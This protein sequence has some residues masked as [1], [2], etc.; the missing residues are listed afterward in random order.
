VHHGAGSTVSRILLGEATKPSHWRSEVF[1]VHGATEAFLHG[2]DVR[3]HPLVFVPCEK[4]SVRSHRT[5]HQREVG[6]D[7]RVA[8]LSVPQAKHV[9]GL[10][11]EPP[12]AGCTSKTRVAS[13]ENVLDLEEGI[14][15]RRHHRRNV[16]WTGIDAVE[17]AKVPEPDEEEGLHDHAC[18]EGRANR[19]GDQSPSPPQPC[20][21]SEGVGRKSGDDGFNGVN[22]RHHLHRPCEQPWDGTAEFVP[23]FGKHCSEEGQCGDEQGDMMEVEAKENGV[24]LGGQFLTEKHAHPNKERQTRHHHGAVLRLGENHAVQRREAL[25]LETHGQA[26]REL[27]MVGHWTCICNDAVRAF[28]HGRRS[29]YLLMKALGGGRPVSSVPAVAPARR[30]RVA[31]ALR[32]QAEGLPRLM[33]ILNVTPD[34]FHAASRVSGDDAVERGLRMVHEGATWLDIGGESTRPGAAPVPVEVEQRRVVDVIAGLRR[35][36]PEVLMSIDTRRPDVAAA[37]IAAGADMVNDVSG[38]RDPAMVDVVLAAGC[39][40]C[41]MHMQGTPSTMQREATYDD[42]VSEVHAVLHATATDLVRRG[43]PAGMICLDPGIGF[44]KTH[45]HNLALLRSANDLRDDGRWPILWGVS[46]KSI[47]G[48]LTGRDD[49]AERLP[50]TLGLAA[51]AVQQGIDVLRVHDVREHRDLLHAM[52]PFLLRG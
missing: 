39:G 41:I 4:E 50:G 18:A 10:D 15:G 36:L 27:L 32:K 22:E 16:A 49:A 45:E 2:M 42:V 29:S 19:D 33:G 3:K 34:S 20:L 6:R 37:A 47:V 14:P 46:R 21:H 8:P 5:G 26:F 30:A 24:D 31:D 48:H 28:D 25:G 40:V 11:H 38:L 44:G 35:A 7:A 12:M 17:I 9:Q 52:E 51:V 13:R 23:E 1:E 43:H